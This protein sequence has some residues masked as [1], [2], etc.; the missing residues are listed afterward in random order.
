MIAGT[1]SFWLCG[2][3]NLPFSGAS[4]LVYWSLAG[5][6]ISVRESSGFFEK[7]GYQSL[8][9]ADKNNDESMQSE[10]CSLQYE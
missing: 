9:I 2:L 4:G 3:V 10:T 7:V 1:I 6:A 5:V 8:E